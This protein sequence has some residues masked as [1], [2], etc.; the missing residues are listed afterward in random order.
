MR[1]QTERSIWSVVLVA[2]AL[3]GAL[4][5]ARVVNA[6]PPAGVEDVQA[7][8]GEV[9]QAVGALDCPPVEVCPACTTGYHLECVADETP[10]EPPEP[11]ADAWRGVVSES[12]EG[13]AVRTYG[14]DELERL[15]PGVVYAE[16]KP[17]DSS[18][19]R[20]ADAGTIA[21]VAAPDGAQY[22][23][24]TYGDEKTDPCN[25]GAG[26]TS[27]V[28]ISYAVDVARGTEVRTRQ[29]VYLPESLRASTW[30]T[31]FTDVESKADGNVGPRAELEWDTV[32]G[33]WRAAVNADKLGQ[34]VVTA[35]L[36]ADA[37]PFGT[38]FELRFTML[39]DESDG[40]YAIAVDGR[41]V[42]RWAGRATLRAGMRGYDR[43][44]VLS[45]ANTGRGY[46]LAYD[47]VRVD[48]R[49]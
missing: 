20:V 37:I 36:P 24:A 48:V 38:W 30:R 49:P 32:R 29:L 9:S 41:E 31:K 8:L 33:Q 4:L 12:Y 17:C 2:L 23:I 14:E 45:T 39:A 26:T 47:L 16:V 46:A 28:M 43:V 15:L 25:P 22:V 34:G 1:T 44:Q 7:A 3:I 35:W 18:G 6:E 40:Y 13:L 42:A 5:F 11:P 27:K 19:F 21:G 10:P